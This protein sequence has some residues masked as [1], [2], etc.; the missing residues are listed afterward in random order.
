MEYR[1]NVDGIKATIE[2]AGKLTANTA[3]HLSAAVE[4]LPVHV[5]DV[6]IDLTDVDY[7]A[8]AGLRALVA[9]DNFAVKRGGVF[10]LLNPCDDVMGVFEM[11]GLSKVLRVER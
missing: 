4:E 8:S 7:V 3:P 6:A 2:V 9:A 1:T 10:Q 11:T 5:C